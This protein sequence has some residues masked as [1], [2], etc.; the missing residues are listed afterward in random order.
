[1]RHEI[2]SST[3][4]SLPDEVR[5]KLASAEAQEATGNW[6]RAGE[7]YIGVADKL[8]PDAARYLEAVIAY[9]RAAA[10]FEFSSQNR[11]AARSYL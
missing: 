9:S 4:S 7:I 8:K 1:M 6:Y 10:C 3:F 5:A 2:C 11:G